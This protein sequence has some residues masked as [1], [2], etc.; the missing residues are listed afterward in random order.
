MSGADLHLACLADEGK[1]GA[2][3]LRQLPVY[4]VV[5]A[6]QHAHCCATGA[7]VVVAQAG[8]EYGCNGNKR[9]RVE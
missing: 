9:V 2:M 3:R 8:H 6:V 1:A 7:R 4:A 5:E